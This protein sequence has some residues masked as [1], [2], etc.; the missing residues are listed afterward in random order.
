MPFLRVPIL[1]QGRPGPQKAARFTAFDRV[2][3]NWLRV[4][5]MV[6]GTLVPPA[7]RF[8]KVARRRLFSP[9]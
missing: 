2:F 5:V 1:P 4:A 7:G 9:V 8:P 6:D 3:V